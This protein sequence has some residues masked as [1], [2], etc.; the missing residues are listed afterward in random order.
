MKSMA[1]MNRNYHRSVYRNSLALEAASPSS[2]AASMEIA[3]YDAAFTG[4][5]PVEGT[6]AQ[7]SPKTSTELLKVLNRIWNLEEQ[8]SCNATLV[9]ALKKELDKARSQIKSLVREQ[10]SDRREIDG[11]VKRIT[12]NKFDDDKSALVRITKEREHEFQSRVLLERLCDEF[13]YKIVEYGKGTNRSTKNSG[14]GREL[15]DMTL[16]FAELWTDQRSLKRN[17]KI[18]T[19]H[20]LRPEIEAFLNRKT[21]RHDDV[22]NPS[23]LRPRSSVT[24][25]SATVDDDDDETDDSNCFEIDRP[26]LQRHEIKKKSGFSPSPSSMQIMFEAPQPAEKNGE[27]SVDAAAKKLHVGSSSSSSQWRNLR[28]PVRE[29]GRKSE[30][31]LRVGPNTARDNS[32]RSKLVD[33]AKGNHGQQRSSRSRLKSLIMSRRG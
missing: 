6:Q 29:W 17:G 22:H 4:G 28:S 7:R 10:Q 27:K 23:A 1:G 19:V 11:I 18:S 16:H 8:N 5:G 9:K 30:S 12:E 33:E 25:V 21:T 2:Y 15:D 20:K 24:A 32:L 3:P 13:A 14:K 31:G 26:R